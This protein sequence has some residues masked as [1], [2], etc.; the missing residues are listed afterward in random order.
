VTIV[1]AVGSGGVIGADGRMPWHL[2]EDLRH[3]R[4]LTLGHTVVMGRRTFESIGRPLDGRRNIV[5]T[6]QPEWHH[7]GVETAR[8]LEE[9]LAL[10]DDVFVIGGGEVYRE[11]MPLADRIY[12][13]RVEG[14]WVGDTFFPTIDPAAWEEISCERHEGFEWCVLMRRRA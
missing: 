9:A 13:T 2:P 4:A 11:A 1:V 6:R 12:L 14:T 7:E 3:F 10:S 8:S 5:L